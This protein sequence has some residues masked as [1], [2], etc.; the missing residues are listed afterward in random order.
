[1]VLLVN[2][3]T[4]PVELVNE[5]LEPVKE[6]SPAVPNDEKLACKLE[7][8]VCPAESPA[9]VSITSTPRLAKLASELARWRVSRYLWMESG[10]HTAGRVTRGCSIRI[11]W[12]SLHGNRNV[13]RSEMLLL[14]TI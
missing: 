4:A 5:S 1:M 12:L 11:C 3:C 13:E 2:E 14:S 10:A 9:R 6:N 7:R 8:G